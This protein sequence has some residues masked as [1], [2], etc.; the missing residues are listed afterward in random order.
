MRR[1][2]AP[3]PGSDNDA[4]LT[5]DF[6]VEPVTASILLPSLDRSKAQLSSELRDTSF[7]RMQALETSTPSTLYLPFRHLQTLA[8]AAIGLVGAT[9]VKEWLVGEQSKKCRHP[10]ASHDRAGD[11]LFSFRV[12][13]CSHVESFAL[14]HSP[15]LLVSGNHHYRCCD[16]SPYS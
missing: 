3:T 13:G 15:G 2:A 12:S 9:A 5:P 16:L 7:S 14:R 4:F 11:A 10:T 8:L 1:L 6:S